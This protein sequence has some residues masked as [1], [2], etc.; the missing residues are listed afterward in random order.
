[1]REE[2]CQE[3]IWQGFSCGHGRPGNSIVN[4]SSYCRWPS[5]GTW[6]SPPYLSRYA[7]L[8]Q[9]RAQE[10]ENEGRGEQEP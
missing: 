2:P 9:K 6:L 10:V 5:I 3:L 8:A 1:M 7:F 4:Y